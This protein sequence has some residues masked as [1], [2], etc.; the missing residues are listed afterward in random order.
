MTWVAQALEKQAGLDTL[1]LFLE[2][3]LMILGRAPILM[4]IITI[5]FKERFADYITRKSLFTC[6]K[7][8]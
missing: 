1:K 4:Q 3:T 2:V 5:L 7:A 6:I 8:G